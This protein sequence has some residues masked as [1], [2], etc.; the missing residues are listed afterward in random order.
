[1]TDMTAELPLTERK[2]WKALTAHHAQLRDRH[3]RDLFDDDPERGQRLTTEA[4]GLF[5]DYSKNLVTDETLR[6]LTQLAEESGLRHR[7]DAM[8][9]GEKINITENRSVLHVALRRQR[10]RR[11]SSMVRMSF[12]WFTRYLKEWQLS[13]HACAA[14]SGR[15]TLANAL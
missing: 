10:R 9:S 6:L 1:M 2:A 13:P 5:L 15:A 7:I 4:V 8:F 14:A 11:L 12:P 3:L